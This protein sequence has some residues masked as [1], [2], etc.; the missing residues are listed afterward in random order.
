MDVF[1]GSRPQPLI[2]SCSSAPRSGEAQG[3]RH[4]A[5]VRT[6]AFLLLIFGGGKVTMLLTILSNAGRQTC[7]TNI[8]PLV[9]TPRGGFS[10]GVVSVILLR[11]Y[12][13][14]IAGNPAITS[15]MPQMVVPY[16]GPRWAA[17]AA[18]LSS[19]KSRFRRRSYHLHRAPQ[20]RSIRH[21]SD[22][23]SD[24][25]RRRADR[26][27]SIGESRSLEHLTR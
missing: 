4:V 8:A 13:V 2:C 14:L 1:G 18:S 20:S 3:R 23:L 11:L 6:N 24:R 21:A 19:G 9:R 22:L 25:F 17:P 27:L 12:L 15:G 7:V 26:S 10:Y 5:S 16:H